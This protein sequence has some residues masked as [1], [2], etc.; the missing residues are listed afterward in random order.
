ME[1]RT[2]TNGNRGL[3]I[4]LGVLALIVLLASLLGGGMMGWGTMGPGMMG[5]WG[6][7]QQPLWLMVL[8]WLS[9]LAFWGALIAGI[10]LLVRWLSGTGNAGSP[11]ED[12]SL[13]ILRRRFAAGEIT[14]EQFDE[15]RQ[16]LG[17]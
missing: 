4:G 17:R 9:M 16:V 6:V 13:A 3:L 12:E 5:N 14:R 1:T 7:G 11:P 15:M 8:G 2:G 10:V